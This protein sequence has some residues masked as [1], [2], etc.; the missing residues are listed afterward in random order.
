MVNALDCRTENDLIVGEIW[1]WRVQKV[2][3]RKELALMP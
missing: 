2:T 1:T 3:V